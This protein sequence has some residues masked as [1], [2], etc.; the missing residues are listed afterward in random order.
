[1]LRFLDSQP[2]RHFLVKK[3]APG[4]VGL[5]PFAIDHELRDSAL[6]GVLYD[7]SRRTWSALD[8]DLLIG[9]VVLREKTLRL[10]A[11]GTPGSRVHNKVH[12]RLDD[13]NATLVAVRKPPKPIR[14]FLDSL[15]FRLSAL[16]NYIAGI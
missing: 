7:F 5:H 6:A 3:S 11:I 14:R 4:H 13:I 1:M 9:N 8:V 2:F 10:A 15:Q 16:V 12:R